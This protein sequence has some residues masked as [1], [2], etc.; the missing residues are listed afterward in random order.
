MSDLPLFPRLFHRASKV[1]D[2]GIDR[3]TL[4]PL[5]PPFIC[6]IQAFMWQQI[7]WALPGLSYGSSCLLIILA[8][9]IPSLL[10]VSLPLNPQGGCCDLSAED[11]RPSSALSILSTAGPGANPSLQVQ[12]HHP[13]CSPI[14]PSP[15][16]PA[17]L[18]AALVRPWGHKNLSISAWVK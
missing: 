18:G 7:L 10:M 5:C 2:I 16:P 11:E 9:N 3:K 6:G 15:R 17:W 8:A 4:Q 12:A 1:L 14:P 13:R